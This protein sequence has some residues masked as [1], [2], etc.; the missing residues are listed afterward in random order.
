[1]ASALLG[2]DVL[3]RRHAQGLIIILK[4]GEVD[5]ADKEAINLL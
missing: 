4:D 2:D 5:A 1:M 3:L